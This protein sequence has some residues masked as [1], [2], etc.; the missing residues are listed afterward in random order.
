MLWQYR[1]DL[2]GSGI[3]SATSALV[4]SYKAAGLPIYAPQ[5]SAPSLSENNEIIVPNS[6]INY[7]IRFT[8]VNSLS[9]WWPANS[10][11]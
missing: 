6:K 11:L 10:L 1:S 3:L 7:P 9:F 5:M 8:W 2:S 4:S